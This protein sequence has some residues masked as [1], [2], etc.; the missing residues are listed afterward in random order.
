MLC[1]LEFYAGYARNVREVKDFKQVINDPKFKNLNANGD[2]TKTQHQISAVGSVGFR[3]YQMDNFSLIGLIYGGRSFFQQEYFKNPS[4]FGGEM[5]IMWSLFKS[6]SIGFIGGLE[7][8]QIQSFKYAYAAPSKPDT[9]DHF[10][11]T[12]APQEPMK[13]FFLGG[14]LNYKMRGGVY[15]SFKYQYLFS[16]E[17]A[18]KSHDASFKSEKGIPGFA[19]SARPDTPTNFDNTTGMSGYRV[20]AGLTIPINIGG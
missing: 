2:N 14:V 7:K 20:M 4:F 8:M 13:G 1:F 6:L 10:I 12:D 9:L 19:F 5:R 18:I 16:K 11:S 3:F 17:A 15:A